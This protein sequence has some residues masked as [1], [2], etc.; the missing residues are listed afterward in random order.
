M[1]VVVFWAGV[2]IS[3][4]GGTGGIAKL[5]SSGLLIGTLIPGALLVILGHRLPRSR[6]THRPRRWTPTT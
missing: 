5:A 2:F 1:I 6:A 4:R 3:A